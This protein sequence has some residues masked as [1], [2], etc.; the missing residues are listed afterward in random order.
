MNQFEQIDIREL[1]PQKEPFIMVGQLLYFDMV[2]TVVS[3]II[4]D[5]NL[6]VEK[7][8]FTQSGLIE[9][10]AQTCA[11]RIGYINKYILKKAIQI[12][13][14][15]AIR[16]LKILGLPKIGDTIVTEINVVEEVFGMILVTAS[17][18][19]G[20]EILTEG[21]MKIAVKEV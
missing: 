10:I 3:T 17:V 2:K 4:N 11:T 9:N 8:I 13:F 15:G 12:G 6:F 7:G 1:L 19:R 20:E 5:D 16:N 21:E 14:I 18:K